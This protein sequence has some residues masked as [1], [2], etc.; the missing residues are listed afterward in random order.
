MATRTRTRRRRVH[1]R[2]DRDLELWSVLARITE[3]LAER[4]GIIAPSVTCSCGCNTRWTDME[5]LERHL[6]GINRRNTPKTTRK[7]GSAANFN[8]AQARSNLARRNA[9]AATMP[10]ISTQ[11]GSVAAPTTSQMLNRAASAAPDEIDENT[12]LGELDSL[13]LS[14]RY[15][16]IRYSEGISELAERMT[17]EIWLDPS[18]A[19]ALEA[20]ATTIAESAQGYQDCRRRIRQVY[21][22]QIEAAS[23]GRRNQP[24][25][26]FFQE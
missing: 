21:A 24:R 2:Y 25:T 5:A 26:E 23:N 19:Q 22:E 15:A 20:T 17:S 1:T 13:L 12:K 6:D 14:L 7:G 10:P 18:I 9:A 3:G 11:G 16:Q 8:A 4:T